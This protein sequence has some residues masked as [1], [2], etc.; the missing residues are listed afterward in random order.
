[1]ILNAVVATAMFPI[2]AYAVEGV[3]LTH[4]VPFDGDFASILLGS[5]SLASGLVKPAD[6][7]I[8]ETRPQERCGQN[9]D[10]ASPDSARDGL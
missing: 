2:W 6:I 7:D 3:A 10:A 9:T 4:V 1:M 5:A 8:Q